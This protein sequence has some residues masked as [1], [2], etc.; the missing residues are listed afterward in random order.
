MATFDIF[1]ANPDTFKSM[2][3]IKHL[4]NAPN[5]PTMMRDMN[6]FRVESVR[7]K[8]IGLDI[9]DEGLELIGFSER[10]SPKQQLGRG[11]RKSLDLEIP[12]MAAETKIYA[13]EIANLRA[14]GSESE[15][16]AVANEVSKKLVYMQNAFH[17]SEE[18][19]ILGAVQ[20]KAYDPKTNSVLYDYHTEFGP[21]AAATVNFALNVA[22][23]K[24]KELC[25]KL[26]IDIQRSA[27]GAWIAG[28]STVEAIVGDQ[29]WFDLTQHENVEKYYENWPA[30]AA[31]HKLNPTDVFVLGGIRFRRY[32]GSDDNSEVAINANEAK[33]F[34]SGGRDIFVKAQA[35][36]DEHLDYVNALGQPSY[37][38]QKT[39]V[40]YMNMPRWIGYDMLAYPLYINQRPQTTRS[41]INA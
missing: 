6:L 7:T 18:K 1:A 23:T 35:P 38:I 12:R 4:E 34:V 30:M 22:T 21:A 29:F 17:Y 41:G 36:A 15:L 40:E 20:A 5:L 28:S 39:D 10:G 33:F 27:K 11:T 32:I 13:A 25:D 14:T 16:M 2:S 26:V 9:S 3:W 8:K 19:M 31:L 24:V 37:L